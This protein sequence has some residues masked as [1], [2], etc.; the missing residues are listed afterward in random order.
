MERSS[1]SAHSVKG[2]EQEARMENWG[3]EASPL[4]ELFQH[5]HHAVVCLQEVFAFT[6]NSEQKK[7]TVILD[8]EKICLQQH[9]QVA[10]K[11]LRTH[12]ALRHHLGFRG[13]VAANIQNRRDDLQMGA[14]STIYAYQNAEASLLH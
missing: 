1:I 2:S 11:L 10:C 3:V 13:R 7:R 6:W 8:Q 9:V 14:T 12:V 5:S 4:R